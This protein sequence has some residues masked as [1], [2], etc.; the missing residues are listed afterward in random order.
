MRNLLGTLLLSTGVPMINAGDELGRSQGGNNNAYCQDNETS[1]IDWDLEPWQEDLLATA[2][3]LARSVATSRRCASGSGPLGRQVHDDGTRDMEWYAADGLLM[4]HRWDDPGVRVVQMYVAVGVAGRRLGPRRR[5]RRP[6][7]RR[8]DAARG[9][10]R[11]GIPAALGQRVGASPAGCRRAT[12]PDR[13]PSP[14]RACASTPPP[15]PPE[16]RSERRRVIAGRARGAACSPH[17]P[18]GSP[19]GRR[20]TASAVVATTPRG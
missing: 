17:S 10:G 12:R 1:W 7:R 3:H 8:G 4:G 19:S 15:T 14:P 18:A 16:R 20:A 11:H 9:A 5:Q 6:G 13:S 2:R